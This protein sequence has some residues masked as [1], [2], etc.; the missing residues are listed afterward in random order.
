VNSFELVQGQQFADIEE[1]KLYHHIIE[2][3]FMQFFPE[4]VETKTEEPFSKIDVSFFMKFAND[5]VPLVQEPL[6]QSRKLDD[7]TND[8]ITLSKFKSYFY[9]HIT[10]T[11]FLIWWSCIMKAASMFD[12]GSTTKNLTKDP[13]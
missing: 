10:L 3:L 12:F 11:T 1:K 13:H 6:T 8:C 4:S 5:K 2:S 9:Y 7:K